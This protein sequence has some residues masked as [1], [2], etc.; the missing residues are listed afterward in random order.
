MYKMLYRR[1]GPGNDASGGM[2]RGAILLFASLLVAAG[3]STRGP[4]EG[5]EPRAPQA[6]VAPAADAPYDLLITN[7]TIVDGTGAPR[8]VGDVAV[9]GDQIVAVEP[10]GVISNAPAHRRLDATGMVVSPGFIDILSHTTTALLRG[11]SRSV[12]KLVQGVT[13]EIL[14]E[15]GTPAPVRPTRAGVNPTDGSAPRRFAGERAFDQWLRAMEARGT[16]PNVAAN[17]GASTIRRLGMVLQSGPATPRAMKM[18][19]DAVRNAMEDG[20]LG[21]SSALIYPP[22][23]FASTEELIELAK[24]VAEYGGNYITHMRSEADYV[25]EAMDE[26]IRIGKEAGL[27]VEI[28]HLKAAGVDNWDKAPKMIAKIDSARAA[29]IDVEANIYPYT[30]AGTGLTTCLPEWVQEGGKLFSNLADPEVR[31]RIRAE[32]ENPTTYWENW[33][34]LATP[35]GVLLVSLRHPENREFTGKRL[36][37]VAEAKGKDWLD[38][39]MDLILTERVRVE[40][41]FFAM[42]EENVK[43]KLQ[44]PWIK[45]GTDAGGRDPSRVRQG[46]FT[47]PRGYGTYG[48]ILGQYVREEG[49]ITLEDAIRKISGAVAT[50]MNLPN[51]GYLKPGYFADIVIFDPETIRDNST[52][53]N[54]HQLTTGVRDVFVNGVTV[55]RNGTHTGAKPGRVIRGP[56]WTGYRK[57]TD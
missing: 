2:L 18:M 43:L 30:A 4:A 40:A 50:R 10:R 8:F 31:A 15:G 6:D 36:S 28:F 49:V 41:I 3:C 13:T 12:S 14:G 42:S 33:C 37:E 56:G 22:G 39:V 44:Q 29:G 35:E 38:T 19:K 57:V 21:L 16:S 54:P 53:E 52:F 25:L 34:R 11:D 45:I 51:R 46:S 7:G 17:V 47:H 48:K 32:M 20:A 23:A 5:P 1:R 24:I 26:A 27:P 9:R 55:V